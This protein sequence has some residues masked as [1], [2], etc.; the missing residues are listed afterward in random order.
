MARPCI[1]T[2]ISRAS[3]NGRIRALMFTLTS[4]VA[5]WIA[6]S[7]A[8]FAAAAQTTAPLTAALHGSGARFGSRTFAVSGSSLAWL[9]WSDLPTSN[10]TLCIATM[11]VKPITGKLVEKPEVFD[12]D[13]DNLG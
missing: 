4:I 1:P 2:P 9:D 11:T 13:K 8:L 7:L 6:V 5:V 12:S 3:T 10:R